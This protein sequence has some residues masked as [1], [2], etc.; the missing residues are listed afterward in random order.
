MS[1][2]EGMIRKADL[3]GGVVVPA[4]LAVAYASFRLITWHES[5]VVSLILLGGG[6][7]SIVIVG[8]YATLI[9][10]EERRNWTGAFI[11][12]SSL[13]PYLLSLFLM[14]Y[15]GLFGLWK[16]A[17]VSRSFWSV[18]AAL[19]WLLVGWRMLFMLGKLQRELGRN[20][21]YRAN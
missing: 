2:T 1:E 7:L 5:S 13:I 9:A 4:I 15:L 20:P 17:T 19:F 8:P 16:A 6:L 10:S 11:A 18:L 12:L 3:I 14:G 21:S